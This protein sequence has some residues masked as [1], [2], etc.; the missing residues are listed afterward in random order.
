MDVSQYF[1]WW[2]LR[3]F[4]SGLARL[5]RPTNHSAFISV[6]APNIWIS[7]RR[8]RFLKFKTRYSLS[9][10]FRLISFYIFATSSLIV[11]N[12]PLLFYSATLIFL[13]IEGAS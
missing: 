6:V 2:Y 8:R 5:T 4:R 13:V 11:A 3:V 9:V 12:Q 1:I 7:I 10:E